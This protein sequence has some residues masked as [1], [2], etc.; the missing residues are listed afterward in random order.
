LNNQVVAFLTLIVY[1]PS[2][3]IFS[4]GIGLYGVISLGVVVLL[5][6]WL[7]PLWREH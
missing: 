6:L 1:K 3:P 4:F 5:I 2:H 7:D